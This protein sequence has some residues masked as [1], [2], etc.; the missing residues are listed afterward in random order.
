MSVESAS[1]QSYSENSPSGL[2]RDGAPYLGSFLPD[3]PPIVGSLTTFAHPETTKKHQKRNIPRKMRHSP[4]NTLVLELVFIKLRPHVEE[5]LESLAK[6]Y[7]VFIFTAAK[8]EY[9]DKILEC[10]GPLRKLIRHQLY[11]EDCL[12][13]QGSYIKDLS[14]LERDLDRVVA[15]ATGLEA[16]PYQ[17]TNVILI[18]RWLGDPQDQELLHLIP[19]LTR[20]SQA[21]QKSVVFCMCS[22]V[23][24][25][26]EKK[27]KATLAPL[28]VVG[29]GFQGTKDGQ[30]VCRPRGSAITWILQVLRTPGPLTAG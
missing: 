24:A 17:P 2:P 23:C 19:V 20:L 18:P 5:F 3:V 12:C 15:V 14:V 11:Q 7:E 9:A 22:S 25:K 4:K 28:T 10:L 27:K 16:F 29:S 6:I 30:G 26:K 8:Q 1:E 13:H 21:S